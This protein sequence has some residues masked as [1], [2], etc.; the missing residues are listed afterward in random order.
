MGGHIEPTAMERRCGALAHTAPLAV[1]LVV[2]WL[3]R[4]SAYV[5][6][7]ARASVNFQITMLVFCGLGIGYVQVY[8]V[9]G[10]TI[11]VSSALLDAVS[12]V[13]AARR[14]LEGKHYEYRISLAVFGD[15]GAGETGE[16][17]AT[18]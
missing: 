5:A 3:K 4:G 15:R 18:G 11:L 17:G 12:S 2:W 6:A 14:A 1:V 9:F 10:L 16:E 13:V 7:H 8:A